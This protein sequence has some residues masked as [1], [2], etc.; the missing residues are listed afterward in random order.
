MKKIV[1]SIILILLVLLFLFFYFHNNKMNKEIT[2]NII[3]TNNMQNNI[4][5]QENF[6]K[7]EDTMPSLNIRMGN[8]N[9]VATLYDNET[10]RQLIQKLP[11]T[12]EMKE[13]NGNEK[14]CYF[15]ESFKT[16]NESIENIKAGDLMLYGSDCLVLFYENFS[17]S[18]NYTK[19]GYIDNPEGLK[20]AVGSG[21]IE[22]TFKIAD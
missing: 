16:N 1:I 13:L 18:Y 17:T 11:L 21:N 22:M 8:Q 14:Y 3:A 6:V 5:N 10:T 20:N 2:K 4:E 12:V 15:D 9:Y 19:I 7:G